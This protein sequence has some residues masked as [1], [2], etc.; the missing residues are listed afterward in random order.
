MTLNSI[1]KPFRYSYNSTS[2]IIMGLNIAVFLLTTSFPK[3]KYLLSLNVLYVTQA[4][5]YWQFFTYMF[6]HGDFSHILFNMLGIFFFGIAVER[7]LGSK[8][9]LLIYFISGFLC[10][11]I[12]FLVY[13]VTGN[14]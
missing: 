14:N 5:A 8:E 4:N 3:L 11:V 12:S 2:L 13:L 9:F 7:A 6:V 1:R 10:G